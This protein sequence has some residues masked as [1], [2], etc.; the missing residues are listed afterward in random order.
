YN[1]I[2]VEGVVRSH[3][4]G[5]W[6]TIWDD[7][8]QVMVRSR[9]TQALRFGD[10]IEAVGY[11]YILGVQTCLH[12]GVYRLPVSMEGAAPATFG[13]ADDGPVRLAERIRD[14]SRE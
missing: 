6:V 4:P 14:L 11:P 10:R 13:A 2:R 8:G 12:G 7:T 1:L 9:Q 5:K 3:E